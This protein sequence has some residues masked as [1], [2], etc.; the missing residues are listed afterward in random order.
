[1]K[2]R[3]MSKDLPFSPAP[4]E[5]AVQGNSKA[6][7]ARGSLSTAGVGMCGAEEH[8]GAWVQL[9]SLKLES[10]GEMDECHPDQHERNQTEIHPREYR[11]IVVAEPGAWGVRIWWY[12]PRHCQHICRIHR[13]WFVFG[14]GPPAA[15]SRCSWRN[16][17]LNRY[18]NSLAELF[19]HWWH[20]PSVSTHRLHAICL[21][22]GVFWLLKA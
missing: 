13:V 22:A 12:G 6:Q 10:R 15:S 16:S 1:M 19:H 7:A 11:A 3:G 2:A 5:G 20:S 21:E 14:L 17:R 18:G 4:V 8:G 9:R